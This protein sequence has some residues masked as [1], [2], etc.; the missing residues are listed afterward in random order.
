MPDNVTESV[1]PSLGYFRANESLQSEVAKCLAELEK[2]NEI[3]TRG[4]LKSQRGGPD[5]FRLSK[6]WIGLKILFSLVVERLLP[7]HQWVSA[8]V[9]CIQEEK[10]D[11]TRES[12]LDYLGNLMEDASDLSWEATKASHAIA[13]TNMEAD[14]FKWTDT[15]KLD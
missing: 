4:R 7:L 6:C 10:S 13:L 3:A 1:V 8:F 2:L 12:M 11:A 9:W 5:D 15:D 14:R